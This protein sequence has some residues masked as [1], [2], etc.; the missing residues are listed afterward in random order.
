MRNP[1]QQVRLLGTDCVP[2][3][4]VGVNPENTGP[5]PP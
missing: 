3:S 1:R 4:G 5:I 2:V